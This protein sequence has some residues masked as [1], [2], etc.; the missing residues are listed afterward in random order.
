MKLM[1]CNMKTEHAGLSGFES[2]VPAKS[3]LL[4]KKVV[5]IEHT[6]GVLIDHAHNSPPAVETRIGR[7]TALLNTPLT[8][9][10]GLHVWGKP[11]K[12]QAFIRLLNTP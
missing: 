4:G 8:T 10:M 9:G 5:D 2:F 7:G 12:L 1:E 11:E 3:S 6:C